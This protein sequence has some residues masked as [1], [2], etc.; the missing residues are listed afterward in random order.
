[1]NCD[2]S[3]HFP[4]IKRNQMYYF[5]TMKNIYVFSIILFQEIIN[6]GFLFVF[7]ATQLVGYIRSIN[8]NNT[9]N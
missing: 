5:N 7:T 3:K 1:M 4:Y 9:L 2:L 8:R 6:K